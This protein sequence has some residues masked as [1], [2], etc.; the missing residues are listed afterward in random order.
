MKKLIFI[1]SLVVSSLTFGQE[2]VPYEALGSWYNLDQEILTISRE[3]Q[4]VVF[5]RK[6]KTA[7]LATGQ[8]TMVD[9]RMHIN[10][11]DTDDSYRLAW[12]IG[13]DTMAINKPRSIRAWLWIRLQ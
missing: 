10:R 2:E 12:F 7:I 1:L 8:I 6:S 3:N 9:G 11:Y 5:V 13:N 4:K